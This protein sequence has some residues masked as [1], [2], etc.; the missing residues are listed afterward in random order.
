MTKQKT[1]HRETDLA[2]RNQLVGYIQATHNVSKA[3]EALHIP[4][5]T[6]QDIWSHFNVAG[7]VKN[8]KRSGR[9]RATTEQ[10][11]NHLEREA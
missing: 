5:S 3:A 8:E 10:D 2:M 7:H 11:D 1:S 6:A 4:C 9:P